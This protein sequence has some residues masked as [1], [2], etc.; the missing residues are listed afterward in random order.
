MSIRNFSADK[1]LSVRKAENVTAIYEPIF[2]EMWKLGRL[3]TL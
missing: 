3:A 1:E 2:Y